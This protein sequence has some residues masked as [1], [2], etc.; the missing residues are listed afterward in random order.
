MTPLSEPRAGLAL[1]LVLGAALLSASVPSAGAAGLGDPV[2]PSRGNTGY[3]ALAYDLAFDHRA[4]TRTVDGTAVI[5]VRPDRTLAHL[6]LDA[7]GLTVHAVRVG[8]RPGDKA[9]FTIAVTAPDAL[10]GVADGELTRT[11]PHPDGRTTRRYVSRE[12]TV[13]ELVQG[14]RRLL[15]PAVPVRP[16]LAGR[17][18]PHHAD[19]PDARRPPPRRPVAHDSGPVASPTAANL[20]Y[21]QRYA[22]GVLVLFAL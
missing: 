5:T 3:R 4:D 17:P 6:E 11:G 15:R 20:F 14:P 13:T 16:R 10:L 18:G 22:G 21:G 12:P 8:D 2:F 1:S 19:R 9:R 7:L